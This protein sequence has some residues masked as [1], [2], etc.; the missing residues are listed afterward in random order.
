VH[1]E[2]AAWTRAALAGID[3]LSG[4]R[5]LDIGS[6]TLHFRTV[7][8]PHIE[9]EVLAPLRSRG[10]QVV[11]LDAKQAPGVDVVC[12][13]DSAGPGLAKRL[14][15]YALVL[16]TGVLQSLAK[17]ERTMD[18]AAAVLARG[19]HLILHVPE[20][21]RRGVDPVDNKLR[22]T[23]DELAAAFEQRG[24]RRVR[25]DSIRID[26]PRYYRGLRSRPSWILA[27]GRWWIPLPG[28]SEQVRRRVPALRWRQSCV[29]MRR[30]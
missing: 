5:A 11:H 14:G 25:A 12:D 22:M 7:E 3:L 24:L 17:P 30:P 27:R 15:E 29:L 26:E 20:T 2:T 16:L 28:V 23:P 1:I 18:L 19:G 8:Q 21:A 4:E 6:S 9:Q 13:L 10:V